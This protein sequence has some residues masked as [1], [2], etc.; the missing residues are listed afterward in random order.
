MVVFA[1]DDSYTMYEMVQ[2][3]PDGNDNNQLKEA[4]K[5]HNAKFHNEG[6]HSAV[7]FSVSSGP[8]V[9][10]LL[11]MMGP[12]KYSDL[13]SRPAGD[14]HDA[15]W[16]KVMEHI[17]T[18]GNVEYWKRDDDLSVFDPDAAPSPMLYIRT[19]KVRQGKGFL[20]GG[21]LKQA[22]AAVKAMAGENSWSVW[23]NE[24][25]QGSRGRHIATV[26][27]LNNWADLED[28]GEARFAEAFKKVHG[29]DA[30]IPFI[31]SRA[32]AYEDWYD[33]IWTMEVDMMAGE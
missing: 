29:E 20:V 33:E 31:R 24:F 13:D 8:E 21:H 27:G 32:L 30:W 15:D 3:T 7:V 2:L 26:S 9:G 28:S 23:D 19:W 11:W 5:S 12:L 1:Q 6:P 17:E 22:S 14:A 16:A 10:T 4:M 25:R 18:V